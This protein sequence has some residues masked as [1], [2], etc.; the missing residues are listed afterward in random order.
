MLLDILVIAGAL[1]KAIGNSV[2]ITFSTYGGD[3]NSFPSRLKITAEWIVERQVIRIYH[4]LSGSDLERV[5]N[6]VA[7]EELVL[8]EFVKKAKAGYI[9]KLQEMKSK[10]EMEIR[11]APKTKEYQDR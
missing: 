5:N 1:E 10:I 2:Q 8:S 6:I 9:K 4:V 3:T 7:M 11:N